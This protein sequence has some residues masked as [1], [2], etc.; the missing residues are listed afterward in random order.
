MGA[1]AHEISLSTFVKAV[2]RNSI[3]LIG[4]KAEYESL[5]ENQR[6]LIAW[7]YPYV[8]TDVSMVKNNQGNMA[9]QTTALLMLIPK[10]PWVS[11]M[12][13][14]SLHIKTIQYKKSY[15]L[16][17]NLVFIAAKRLYLNY[18]ITKEKYDIYTQREN[19][20][21]SQL[22]IAKDKVDAGSMSKKDYIN[23]RNSYLESKLAKTNVESM[24]INL[25]KTL[26]TLLA[27]V[28]PNPDNA[29]FSVFLDDAHSVKVSGLG[30]E[31]VKIED[32]GLKQILDHSL[33]VDIIDLSAKDY[34]TNAKLANRDRFNTLEVGAGVENANSSTN[35]SLKFQIPL[36][37]TPK[38]TH[39]KRKYMALESGALAQS[40][41]IKRNIRIQT[42]SYM[43]QLKNKE[44][45]I[46]IQKE[47]IQNKKHLMEMGKIAYESQKIG[48]FE[49]LIYQNSYM[50][51]LI[52]LAEA[53]LDY[54]NT[55]ALLEETLGKSLTDI[56]ENK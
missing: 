41:V 25:E 51:A 53:K 32:S 26:D 19:N 38:N 36:P 29:N 4:K 22:K 28:E 10:L 34:Q 37:L 13:Y 2:E 43:S 42:N 44:K 55:T 33:Y 52:A 17:K 50:D 24:L 16:S 9:P 27:I 21:L 23:F 1:F 56:G 46:E 12:L 6:S 5:L 45:Y 14:Q 3:E 54:V 8:E 48:L 20:Y 7:D 15:E 18:V 39:L 47:N 11:T 49:Y 31:Y 30:F 40:E 35:V